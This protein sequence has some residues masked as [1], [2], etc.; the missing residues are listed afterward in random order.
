M[1]I[2][3][4]PAGDI[5]SSA[6]RKSI[7]GFF[8]IHRGRPERLPTET[9]P[10]VTVTKSNDTL[11]VDEALNWLAWFSFWYRATVVAWCN[12]KDMP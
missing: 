8:A 2:L 12:Q 4:T 9:L 7:G 10:L 5:V 1:R 3:T 6:V 11:M